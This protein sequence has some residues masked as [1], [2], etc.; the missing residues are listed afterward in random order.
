MAYRED[1]KER[2]R[3]GGPGGFK[4]GARGAAAG[5]RRE[6]KD[7]VLSAARFRKKTCRFCEEKLNV[8]DYKDMKRIERLV[9]ERGKILSRRI[10]GM[11]AKHQRK[12]EEAVKKARFLAL[13]PYLKK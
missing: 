4:G 11:C 5:R 10:T 9:G 2:G 7:D 12:V 1:R 6:K 13:L 3:D 8:L